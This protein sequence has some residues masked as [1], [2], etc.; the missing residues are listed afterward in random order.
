MEIIHVILILSIVNFVG[1][2]FLVA[3]LFLRDVDVT[4][5]E[6]NHIYHPPREVDTSFA[7]TASLPLVQILDLHG[8]CLGRRE[9]GHPDIDYALRT[10]GL[11]VQ[12]LDGTVEKGNQ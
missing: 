8:N 9:P 3:L 6:P 5:A 11:Q 7:P 10:P 2:L 4:V 1:N 12:N